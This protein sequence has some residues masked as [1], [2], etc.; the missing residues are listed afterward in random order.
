MERKK[1]ER[2]KQSQNEYFDNHV[3]GTTNVV[4]RTTDNL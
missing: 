2:E 3:L 1:M 4:P